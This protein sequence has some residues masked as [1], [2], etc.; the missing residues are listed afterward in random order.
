[1]ADA[2]NPKDRDAT[3]EA[4]SRPVKPSTQ[5]VPEHF[6]V[7]A[8]AAAMA[9]LLAG[10]QATWA[11]VQFFNV[12]WIAG[13]T[14]GTF[15][16]YLWIWAIL[17]LLIAASFLYAGYQILSGGR[18]GYIYGVIIAGFSAVRWFFYLPA[19]PV[20]GVVIIAIDIFVIYGLATNTAY[21]RARAS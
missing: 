13:T 12:A 6:P 10:F 15:N 5:P 18:H 17:D 16:G 7:V 9:F 2:T 21:F 1:M 4:T 14:Y 19:A 3:S 11:I 8:F 20:L